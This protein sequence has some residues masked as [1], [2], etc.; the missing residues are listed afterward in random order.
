MTSLTEQMEMLQKQQGILNEKIKER[1]EEEKKRKDGYTLER[2][3]TCNKGGD[4]RRKHLA[5]Q[6]NRSL[7]ATS[8]LIMLNHTNHIFDIILE[9]FKKQ[10]ARINELE[11]RLES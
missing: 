4:K 5:K 9:I 7:Q 10:N 8:E 11:P 6:R 3:E 2:L 1:M